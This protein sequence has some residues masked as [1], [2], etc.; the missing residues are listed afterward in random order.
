MLAMSR[1]RLAAFATKGISPP[2]GDF[3]AVG[4][5]PAKGHRA[6]WVAADWPH[7]VRSVVAREDGYVQPVKLYPM[8]WAMAYAEM[9]GV[10]LTHVAKYQVDADP[11]TH[12]SIP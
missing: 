9:L 8:T 10:P 6:D 2:L 7:V 5:Q 4:V 3:P 11:T 12:R 1:Y